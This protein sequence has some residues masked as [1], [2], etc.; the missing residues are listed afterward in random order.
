[1][2]VAVVLLKGFLWEM[3]ETA[4]VVL[5]AAVFPD[6]AVLEDF[7]ADLDRLLTIL[8]MV[9]VVAVVVLVV[10][11]LPVLLVPAVMEA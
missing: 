8:V 1:L 10:R 9:A 7:L 6:L 2:V 4:V 5:M 3:A 11:V